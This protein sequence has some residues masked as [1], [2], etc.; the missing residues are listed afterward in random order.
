MAKNTLFNLLKG[1]HMY[2]FVQRNIKNLRSEL[3]NHYRSQDKY[4]FTCLIT[5]KSQRQLDEKNSISLLIVFKVPFLVVSK[6]SSEST[7]SVLIC[8]VSLSQEKVSFYLKINI[9]DK[10][11][12]AQYP[13]RLFV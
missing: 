9:V 11:E 2:R 6:L 5:C 4:Q 7:Y 12:A 10:K 3:E 8:I 1:P 13:V